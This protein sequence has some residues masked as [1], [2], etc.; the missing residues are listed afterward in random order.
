MKLD[1]T[2]SW[3]QRGDASGCFRGESSEL[4]GG[5]VGGGGVGHQMSVCAALGLVRKKITTK[6]QQKFNPSKHFVTNL[7]LLFPITIS[8]SFSWLNHSNKIN[9]IKAKPFN[10][11]YM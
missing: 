10:L 2:S 8:I 1:F 9:N 3:K 6:Q 11:V 7:S 5:R 4:N